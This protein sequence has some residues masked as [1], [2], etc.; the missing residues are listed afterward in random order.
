MKYLLDTDTLI[1]VLEDRGTTRRQVTAMIESGT[2]VALCAITIVEIYSGL[3]EKKRTKWKNWLL[4]LPYWH[5]SRAAAQRAG[6]DRKT[7]SDGGRTFSVTDS[8][9]AA[10]ARENDATVLTSNIKDYPM[11]D[12]QVR[13]LREHAA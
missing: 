7:A 12:V 8:L 5:I 2:E 11:N 6:V 13:S 10:V 3:N 9:I 1:D 4:A